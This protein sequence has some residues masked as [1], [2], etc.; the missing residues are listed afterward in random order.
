MTHYQFVM[1][2]SPYNAPK[3]DK[4]QK[5]ICGYD[6]NMGI[7][8]SKATYYTHKTKS[9]K[10][11]RLCNKIMERPCTCTSGRLLYEL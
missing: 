11:H 5:K 3:N 8:N 4:F 2:N 6:V 9:M 1:Y 10:K 7:D